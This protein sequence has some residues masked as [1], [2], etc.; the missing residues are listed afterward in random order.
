VD[1]DDTLT[2]NCGGITQSAPI[3]WQLLGRGGCR[4]LFVCSRSTGDGGI[5]GKRTTRP[6]LRS[7]RFGCRACLSLTYRSRSQ[8]ARVRAGIKAQRIRRR[9]GASSDL[10][11]PVPL[12]PK[13]MPMRRYLRLLAEA[14]RAVRRWGGP[15]VRPKE[16]KNG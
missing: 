14:Q 6:Y 4:H 15:A 1:G 12:R 11:S 16:A 13:R 7:D 8:N 5:C 10:F 2:L 9:L 3:T